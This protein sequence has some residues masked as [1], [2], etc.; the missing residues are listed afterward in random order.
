MKR[1]LGGVKKDKWMKNIMIYGMLDTWATNDEVNT[2]D[3]AN[4]EAL[5]DHL[6]FMSAQQ[7]LLALA[8]Y[9]QWNKKC[10]AR[11]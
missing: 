1:S 4:V 11:I 9:D 2:N 6:K 7:N 8:Q 5:L 10:L 3:V